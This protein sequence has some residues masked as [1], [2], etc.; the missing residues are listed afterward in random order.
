MKGEIITAYVD[1]NVGRHP[2][3][4]LLSDSPD[5]IVVVAVVIG[6]VEL[7]QPCPFAAATIALPPPLVDI[8]V[9]ESDSWRNMINKLSVVA[10]V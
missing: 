10:S 8:V 3:I 4:L 6:D 2:D 5:R 7:L 1:P 9:S